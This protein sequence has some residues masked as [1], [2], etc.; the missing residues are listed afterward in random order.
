LDNFLTNNFEKRAVP[1]QM[2]KLSR[3]QAACSPSYETRYLLENL[4]RR[5]SAK[6]FGDFLLA[7]GSTCEEL[8]ACVRAEFLGSNTEAAATA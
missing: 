1:C 7:S 4:I 2:P 3:W 5:I 6:R 8:G